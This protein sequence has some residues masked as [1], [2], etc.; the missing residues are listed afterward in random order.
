M[1]THSQGAVSG[2]PRRHPCLI[3]GVS[4]EARGAPGLTLLSAQG[5]HAVAPQP[6]WALSHH[7][8]KVLP[9]SPGRG[10]GAPSPTRAAA[11][12][13]PS[14]PGSQPARARIPR[15]SP[16]HLS[17]GLF[18][19]PSVPVTSLTKIAPSHPGP[20]V[21]TSKG[22]V[23][24]Q[25][26]QPPATA[27]PRRASSASRPRRGMSELPQGTAHGPFSSRPGPS[28]YPSEAPPGGR[29][30][31]FRPHLE[32]QFFR[33]LF[34]AKTE[35]GPSVTSSPRPSLRLVA[36]HAQRLGCRSGSSIS[37]VSCVHSVRCDLHRGVTSIALLTEMG[38]PGAPRAMGDAQPS[39]PGV[40][41]FPIRE[42]HLDQIEDKNCL[43]RGETQRGYENPCGRGKADIEVA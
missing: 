26:P 7:Y 11:A 8:P 4:A 5:V 10:N 25:L 30:P 36:A 21:T 13:S 38:V 31:L 41:C 35:W 18:Q 16:F 39:S 14:W 42:V 28:S 20:R 2:K 15:L 12:A 3:P 34:R 17:F 29:S 9:A 43:S 27:P 6:H 37:P 1:H 32:H 40:R 33:R 24:S 19:S 22:R 23:C